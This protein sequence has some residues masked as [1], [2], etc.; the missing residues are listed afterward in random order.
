MYLLIKFQFDI[1]FVNILAE[2]CT[3]HNNN[4][5]EMKLLQSEMIVI[6]ALVSGEKSLQT[7]ILTHSSFDDEKFSFYLQK[8]FM[9][10]YLKFNFKYSHFTIINWNSLRFYFCA[11]RIKSIEISF[12]KKLYWIVKKNLIFQMTENFQWKFRMKNLIKILLIFISFA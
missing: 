1:T 8:L 5:D 3:L 9:H 12:L 6:F 4:R 11:K 10:E 2:Y 7:F